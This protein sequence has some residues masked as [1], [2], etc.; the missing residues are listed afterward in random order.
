M[1]HYKEIGTLYKILNYDTYHN[2]GLTLWERITLH[3]AILK[4][5]KTQQIIEFDFSEKIQELRE[6]VIEENY[7]PETWRYNE[8]LVLTKK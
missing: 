8:N 3:Q 1:E 5:A 6:K 7:Q 2:G 4:I